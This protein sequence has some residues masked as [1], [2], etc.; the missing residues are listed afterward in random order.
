[1]GSDRFSIGIYVEPSGNAPFRQW[2][3]KLK[4]VVGRQKIDARI[5]RVRA[6]NFGDHRAVGAGVSEIRI[7]YGPGYRIY[8]GIE[9]D[10]VVVLLCGGDKSTQE[11]DI[12]TARKYW[13]DY[14]R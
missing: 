14:S 9:G 2:R 1:M 10:T 12:K 13:K 6:G 8:Y 4:D 7:D 5:A 11:T 3:G